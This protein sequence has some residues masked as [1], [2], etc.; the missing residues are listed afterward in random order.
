M[1]SSLS[2]LTRR[3][4]L[5]RRAGPVYSDPAMTPDIYAYLDYRVYLREWFAARKAA[6]PRFSHRAFVRRAGRASPS[7]LLHVMEGKRDLS[8]Q[9]VADFSRALGLRSEEAGFFAALVDLGQATHPDERARAWDRVSATRRFR[10]ARRLE[11]DGMEYLSAWYYP[12]VRELSLCDGFR[13]EPEW[14]AGHL[15][16]KV[17]PAQAR[18]ALDLLLSMGLL[19]RREDGSVIATQASVVTPHE[20]AGLAAFNF[21]KAMCERGL[22][23]LSDFPYPE[24]H[25]CAVTV[26]IPADLLPR[27]K[28]ELD[29][30]QERLLDLCDGDTRP[31]DRVFQANLQ[32]FP[33]T[34]PVDA[35]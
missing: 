19:E 16:P 23:A 5:T 1:V 13:A 31:K 30:F 21:H 17:T 7:A 32:L 8:A 25:Y 14:I 11:G 9:G 18:K 15:R 4:P 22:H 29:A 6:N 12:A 27:L 35:P 2:G 33:L 34:T 10:E 20:V 3:F 28:Q 26:A 24:R